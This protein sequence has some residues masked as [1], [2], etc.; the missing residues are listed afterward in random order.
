MGWPLVRISD[1]RTV[2]KSISGEMRRKK[3]NRKTNIKV[4][5]FY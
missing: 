5:R 4:V 1:D 2:N 3:K